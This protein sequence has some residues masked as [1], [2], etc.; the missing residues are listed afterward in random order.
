[1]IGAANDAHKKWLHGI[2]MVDLVI[3]LAKQVYIPAGHTIGGSFLR[4][5]AD[6]NRWIIPIHMVIFP[7]RKK[8]SSAA[9][10]PQD[11]F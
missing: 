11:D 3:L 8:G 9:L 10:Q 4:G 5:V 7:G 6:I 1:V 2:V